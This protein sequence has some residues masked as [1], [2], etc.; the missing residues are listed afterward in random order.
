MHMICDIPILF[1]KWKSHAHFLHTSH[2]ATNNP[3]LHTE[4]LCQPL[5]ELF[6]SECH[7]LGRSTSNYIQKHTFQDHYIKY[8]SFSFLQ[9]HC[10]VQS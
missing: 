7:H 6:T 10:V 2:L 5:R 8:I 9:D 1:G 4:I 3:L